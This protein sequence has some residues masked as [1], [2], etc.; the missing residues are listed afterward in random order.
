MAISLL[1]K[2]YLISGG[3]VLNPGFGGPSWS[4]N[5]DFQKIVNKNQKV[6]ITMF[7]NVTPPT[8]VTSNQND[9]RSF[10]DDQKKIVVKP[11]DGMGGRSIFIVEIGDQNTNTIFEER[12]CTA[13]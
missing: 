3:D 1:A 13:T 10:L 2:Q 5:N 8:I 12:K 6:S 7:P 9:L 11:L 4:H